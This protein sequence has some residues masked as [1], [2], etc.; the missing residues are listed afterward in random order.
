MIRTTLSR[1]VIIPIAVIA[2]AGTAASAHA[3]APVKLKP[4]PELLTRA[5]V[6]AALGKPKPI[7]QNYSAASMTPSDIGLC[8]PTTGQPELTVG[9]AAGWLSTVILTGKGYREVNERLNTFATEGAAASTFAE[10]QS[11]AAQCSGMSRSP[12]S[13]DP[14]H[15]ISGRYVNTNSTGMTGTGVWISINTKVRSPDEQIDG[16]V[17]TTYTVY[18]QNLNV[19]T[20]TWIY[21]NGTK[22][23]TASQRR[24][25][26]N[27]SLKLTTS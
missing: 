25:V 10:L 1:I 2:V 16:S 26:N 19:I 7:A 21:F 14:S 17:T 8:T 4:P 11:A 23:T 27:L 24:A 3:V 9:G 13:D 22:S 5:D 15:P 20:A 6:P 12:I 18:R